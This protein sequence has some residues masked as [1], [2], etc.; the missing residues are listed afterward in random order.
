MRFYF[1][2]LVIASYF[3]VSCNLISHDVLIDNPSNDKIQVHIDDE[4][5]ILSPK[6]SIEINITHGVHQIS[7]YSDSSTKAIKSWKDCAIKK[8]G[9]LNICNVEYIIEN[10]YFR[11]K[12]NVNSIDIENK[13][14]DI[15]AYT[16]HG[17]IIKTDSSQLFIEKTWDKGLNEELLNIEKVNPFNKTLIK[18]YRKEEFVNDFLR[19]VR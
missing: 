7:I 5:F 18:I 17:D 13:S 3:I 15:D 11:N 4:N 14:I 16:Y 6:S 9:I 2:Y 1:A 8:S 12:E 19:N 10:N